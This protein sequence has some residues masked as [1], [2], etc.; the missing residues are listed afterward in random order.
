L[1]CGKAHPSTHRSLEQQKLLL[2]HTKPM[3]RI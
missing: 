2:Q 1:L 3:L